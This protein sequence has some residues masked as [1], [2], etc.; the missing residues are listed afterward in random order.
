MSWKRVG[1]ASIVN[2]PIPLVYEEIRMKL[3]FRADLI[4]ENEAVVEIKSFEAIAPV[5]KEQL[6]D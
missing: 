1:S 2:G 6:L 3:G 5:H 4:V